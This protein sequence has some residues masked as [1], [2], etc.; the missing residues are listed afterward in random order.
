MIFLLQDRLRLQLVLVQ[1]EGLYNPQE[2]KRAR[3]IWHKAS[4]LTWGPMLKD[5]TINSCAIN[6][7]E[8][9]EKLLYRPSITK[10]QIDRLKACFKRI[11]DNTLWL[12]P[13]KDIDAKL[14]TSTKQDAL[15]NQYG[16]TK[17]Y[18]VTGNKE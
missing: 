17:Y 9:R 5:I 11:F 12:S 3:R 18:V 6:L 13:D 10:D 16:L 4:V 1:Q 2:Q 15:F 14:T 8:E 7:E